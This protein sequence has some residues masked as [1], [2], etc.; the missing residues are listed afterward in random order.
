MDPGRFE[1]PAEPTDLGGLGALFGGGQASGEDGQS[2]GGLGGLLGAFSR[3][4]AQ[5]DG[6]DAAGDEG[7][8]E[9]NPAE[10]LSNALRGIFGR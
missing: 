4:P 9:A 1:L 8:Q 5:D 2:Q 10:D 3:K 7:G 6:E